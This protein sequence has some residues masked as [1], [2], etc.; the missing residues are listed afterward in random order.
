MEGSSGHWERGS[1]CGTT[2]ERRQTVCQLSESLA[3]VPCLPPCRSC[4]WPSKFSMH[5]CPLPHL[6]RRLLCRSLPSVIISC[7]SAYVSENCPFEILSARNPSRVPP[8]IPCQPHRVQEGS[9]AVLTCVWEDC[10]LFYH[11]LPRNSYSSFKAPPSSS[12]PPCQG[13]VMLPSCLA[14]ML[15]CH[16]TCLYLLPDRPQVT[17]SLLCQQDQPGQGQKGAADWGLMNIIK[18]L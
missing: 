10:F 6:S 8:S 13:Q 7:I 12:S 2:W 14:L 4:W 15:W 1:V 3:D 9:A 5:P 17:C 16:S 11:T 18:A